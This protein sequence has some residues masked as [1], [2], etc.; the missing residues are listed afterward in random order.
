[1][2]W[3]FLA[4]LAPFIYAVNVFLDK[5]LVEAMLPNYRSLPIFT[6]ILAGIFSLILLV[7]FD[8]NLQPND[9]FLVILTG[10]F[11]IFASALYIEA[12]VREEG[13]IIIILIQL[14]PIFVLTLSALFLGE[15][16]TSK[17]LLGFTL[18]LLASLLVSVKKERTTFKFSKAL[19]YILLADICWSI[20]YILIKFASTSISYPNL[21]MYES[22]GIAL[23]GLL[24]FL[25][26]EKTRTA[27]LKTIKK[28]SGSTLGLLTLNESLYVLGKSFT[29]LAITLGPVALISA[30]GS[31]QVFFGIL[32]GVSL[33]LILPKVFKEDLSKKSLIKKGALGLLAFSA[34]YLIS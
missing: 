4:L 18:L 26:L 28:I 1:M 5:Y 19:I 27:F 16:F 14:T 20:P 30:L 2:N 29:Y 10:I 8:F 25:I 34:V 23:G 24:L 7:S 15:T 12:L 13:S 3:I 33:T 32:L 6:S 22:L 9:S 17:Q 21:L 11:T 31:T